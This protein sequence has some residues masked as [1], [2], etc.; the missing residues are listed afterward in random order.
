MLNAP[1]DIMPFVQTAADGG[2]GSR[3][4]LL[5]GGAKR[6]APGA[7]RNQA[8]MVRPDAHPAGEAELI[9]NLGGAEQDDHAANVPQLA[10]KGA[11]YKCIN[12]APLARADA[13]SL[14][15]NRCPGHLVLQN[16]G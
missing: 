3:A 15:S 1:L 9:A 13:Q 10:L 14:G 6:I 11:S 2:A 5:Q 16:D 8:Q 4:G 12:K 7:R